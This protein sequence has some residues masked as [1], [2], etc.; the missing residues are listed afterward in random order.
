[1]SSSQLFC[2]NI[3]CPARGQVGK[4]N[5]GIHDQKKKRYICHVC[6]RT[7]STSKGTLFYRLRTEP[8]T[9][10]L[11]IAL[12]VYGCPVQ[13]I[14]Q[15]FEIDERTVR[16]WWRRAGLHCQTF[17]EHL[18]DQNQL[19]LGQIQADE[20]KVR[21][22]KGSIW[23][24][25]AMMVSTRLWLGGAVSPNRDTRLLQQMAR[26]VRRVALCRPLLIAVDGLNTY[27]SVFRD[28]FRT[29]I[30][31]AKGQ[32]GR[33]TLVAWPNITIVQV[34]KSKQAGVLNIKRV[35]VQG[36]QTMIEQIIR[37]TQGKGMINTAYIERLNATFRQRLACL[38]RRTRHL[39]RHPMTL[40]TSMYILG[41]VYNFCDFHKSLRLRLSVGRN[42]SRWVQRTPALAAQL[43]D[44][45]WSLEEL[46]ITKIPPPPWVKKQGRGRFTNR[47]LLRM[48]RY[49]V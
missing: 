3:E 44:H 12:L 14:V 25:M 24:A 38:F 36:Q 45:C 10:L 1:M 49:L 41:C 4:N 32:T 21:T 35:I 26:Q 28:A 8:K 18:L 5:I 16:N 19:E 42:G 34:I 39:A 30:P 27:L 7:F 40:H 46:F 2:P 48:A 20:I 17:H 47:L 13:A 31:R 15:A 37:T 11:V 6:E 43:T 9:V 23:M 29:G 33:M 22:Q